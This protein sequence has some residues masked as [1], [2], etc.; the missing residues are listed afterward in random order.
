MSD[1][2]INSSAHKEVH[3]KETKQRIV[4]EG[5]CCFSE[6]PVD[7]SQIPG[8][9]SYSRKLVMTKEV[10]I[11]CYKKWI[12]EESESTIGSDNDK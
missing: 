9:C 12:L 3:M 8:H 6:T 4:I 10:F 5:D 1:T 7:L 11:E 2:V